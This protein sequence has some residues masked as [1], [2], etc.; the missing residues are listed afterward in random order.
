M[1]FL[2]VLQIIDG[3][4]ISGRKKKRA[5]SL[6]THIRGASQKLGVPTICTCGFYLSE[7]SYDGLKVFFP[8]KW[9]AGMVLLVH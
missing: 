3:D 8:V 9:H 4:N 2:E 1:L 5:L 6:R 7:N